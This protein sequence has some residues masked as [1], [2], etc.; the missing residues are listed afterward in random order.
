MATYRVNIHTVLPSDEDGPIKI[1]SGAVNTVLVVETS[2]FALLNE[3]FKDFIDEL[4]EDGLEEYRVELYEA[5][6]EGDFNLVGLQV[7]KTLTG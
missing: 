6:A 1:L 4:K 2:D 5:T 7:G 3:H